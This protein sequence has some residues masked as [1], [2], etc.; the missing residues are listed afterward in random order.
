MAGIMNHEVQ[1]GDVVVVRYEGPGGVVVA[2]VQQGSPAER[3]GLMRGDVIEEIEREPVK[4]PAEVGKALEKGG[5]L[6][7]LRRQGGTFYAVV[8]R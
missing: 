3:A 6:F 1:P 2:E 4:S 5:A 7:T 8:K